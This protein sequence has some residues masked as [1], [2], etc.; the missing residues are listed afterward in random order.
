CSFV[1]ILQW[2]PAY[3]IRECLPGDLIGGITT[4]I[5]H[6]PTGLAYAALAGVDPIYGLYSSC[7][8]AF[9]Y[10][11]FGTSRHNSLGSF[12]VVSLM[13]GI[14]NDNIM[15]IRDAS[16]SLDPTNSTIPA[17]LTPI[18]VATTLTFA[19][20]IVQFS[21]GL[22]RLDFLASYFS[23]SLVS[24][25]TTG[26]AVH[27]AIAQVDDLFGLTGLPKASGPGYLFR[28]SWDITLAVIDR[29]NSVALLTSVVAIG[30]LHCGR[31]YLSPI[32]KRKGLKLP[33][34]YDLFVMLGSTAIS[35]AFDFEHTYNVPI[36]GHIPTGPPAPALPVIA[37]LPDCLIQSLGMVAV[38]VA[39]HI[40]LAKMYSK[41]LGYTIDA[42]QELYALG[43]SSMLGGLFSV[44]PIANGFGRTAVNV[45]SGTKTQLS[46]M[47]SCTLLLVIILWLGPL[48]EALPR[49]ILACVI[50]VALQSMFKRGEELK[51]LWRVSRIDL[52]VWIV[53]FTAT[54]VI[55]VMEGMT[56]SIA[57]ALL[58][59]VFR[60]QW[61]KWENVLGPMSGDSTL[62]EDS[63]RPSVCVFR[64][65]GPLI[66]TNTER[67]VNK[68]KTTIDEWE[69]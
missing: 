35:Y 45:A 46:T 6:V 8:P 20:G 28:R 7:F 3:N 48:L 17:D 15:R 29:T 13:A 63:S 16:I 61:P 66:F 40:S 33:V 43:A 55:D 42:R 30:I 56:I 26:S 32:I 68:V 5:V 59:V 2:L 52:A 41:K 10:M 21:A 51:T 23:D 18:Q 53:S 60:S 38:S 34:P 44:Y 58:T 19:I 4:G 25:F 49:C 24:G 1:P 64:F 14:A 22:L 50:I 36:V 9:F 57:F 27:V 65:D 62:P 67:F 12:A 54:V 47:F 37:I 31:E 39:T 69:G 11:L